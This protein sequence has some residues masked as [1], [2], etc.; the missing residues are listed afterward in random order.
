[1]ITESPAA[2][3]HSKTACKVTNNTNNASNNSQIKW[4]IRAAVV[5][6][7]QQ[8]GFNNRRRRRAIGEEKEGKE[9]LQEIDEISKKDKCTITLKTIKW[10]LI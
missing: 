2:P 6:T 4:D 1:M 9:S 10:F 3:I 5:A 8:V 7:L